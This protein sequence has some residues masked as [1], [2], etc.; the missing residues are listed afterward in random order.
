LA[1]H[2]TRGSGK[3][4]GYYQKEMIVRADDKMDTGSP[5]TI[6]EALLM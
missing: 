2:G 5:T 1:I 6:Y 4:E 3:G